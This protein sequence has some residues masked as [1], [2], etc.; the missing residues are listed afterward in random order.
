[1]VS[2]ERSHDLRQ[3]VG[4]GADIVQ[5]SKSSHLISDYDICLGG[6]EASF[7]SPDLS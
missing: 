2:P 4:S 7:K 1:M 3:M 5:Y 6:Q